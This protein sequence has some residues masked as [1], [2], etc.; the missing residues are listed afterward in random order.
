MLKRIP[1]IP[2]WLL[3]AMLL[4]LLTT[5]SWAQTVS[6][7]KGDYAPGETAIITGSG[8]HANETVT[9]QVKHADGTAE[10]GHGHDPFTAATD[11]DGKFG[12]SWYVD[13]DDS[14]G[15][16]LKLT[17]DCQHP[18]PDPAHLHAECTF[19]DTAP[20]HLTVTANC[21]GAIPGSFHISYRNPA[22][23]SVS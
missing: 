17:A 6:T 3:S 12:S 22:N 13:P 4:L 16:T 14:G 10:G 1:A 23:N 7:D 20:F 21:S 5:C 18:G 9:L 15:S 19:T 8:F 2:T 11:A